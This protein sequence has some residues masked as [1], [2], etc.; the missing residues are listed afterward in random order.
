ME[1][2]SETQASVQNDLRLIVL[3]DIELAG[4]AKELI[5]AGQ[6]VRIETEQDVSIAVEHINRINQCSKLMEAERAERLLPLR[7]ATEQIN[8]PYREH[9][10][11]L[12]AVKENITAMLD[13][14]H[15][16]KK[17]IA[18]EKA[19]AEQKEREAVAMAEAK[20]IE[21][22]R[23]EREQE[24]QRLE[25]LR[26][27]R[28][29]EAKRL[30]EQGD[31]EAAAVAQVAAA[32]AAVESKQK[33]DEAEAKRI[34]AEQVMQNA[35]DAPIEAPEAVTMK[36]IHGSSGSARTTWHWE[37][38]DI[39]K[40]PEEFITV[41]EKELNALVKAGR[42]EIPGLRIYSSTKTVVR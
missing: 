17:R 20:K 33:A 40:V 39:S 2:H 23:L 18:Q 41:K 37:I 1:Q 19:D 25:N 42:R 35:A 15:A 7:N 6:D 21:D 28:E 5:L 9:K 4:K 13:K 34:E 38:T 12:M 31:A 24:A 36:G 14:W 26:L 29:S 22:E 32:Q 10:T 3:R 16:N 27:E 30:K 8:A 11:G